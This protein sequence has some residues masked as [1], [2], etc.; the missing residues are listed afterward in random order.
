MRPPRSTELGEG[1][2]NAQLAAMAEGALLPIVEGFERACMDK[3]VSLA[4]SSD[5]PP[6]AVWVMLGELSGYANIRAQ[7]RSAKAGISKLEK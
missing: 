6:H 5:V 7:I 4:R 3:L 2:R 1:V